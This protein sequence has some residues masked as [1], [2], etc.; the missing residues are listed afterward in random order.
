MP[1]A[2]L[3]SRI[4]KCGTQLFTC[5]QNRK[6]SLFNKAQWMGRL[7]DWS[8]RNDLFKAA[9]FRF[10]DVFPVLRSRESLM[11]HVREYF[12][13]GEAEAPSFMKWGIRMASYGGFVGDEILNGIIHLSVRN[14]AKQFII[15]ENVIQAMKAIEGLRKRGF[16]FTLDILGEATIT[17]EEA[18]Q[19]ELVYFELL[20]NLEKAQRYWT[21]IPAHGMNF[22][23]NKDWGYSPF[24]QISV[25]IS[26]L[27][28]QIRPVD[29]ENSVQ[30]ILGPLKKIY[31]KVIEIGGA[32][33][34][35][36]ESS[37]YKAMTLE[38]FKRLRA[39][40]E[41]RHYVHLGIAIQAY[42]RDTPKDL[43]DLIDWAKCNALPIE[44][45]LVK[46]A[47]WDYEVAIA[48][49]NNWT[50]AVLTEKKETD[51]AFEALARMILENYEV[52]Y[53]ACGSH[54][55]RSI[56]AVIEIAKELKVP[57][58]AYEFQVLYGMAEPI[59]NALRDFVG[60]VRLYCPYGEMISGMAY[61][62]RRLLENT[63]NESFLRQS[64]V[65]GVDIK[66]LLM[67]PKN[68]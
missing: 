15:G 62:V 10:V 68:N 25:K 27:Y 49:Q 67:N 12:I 4:V 26:G 51:A 53:L 18:K 43:E 52:C 22:D 36:M 14:M 20:E 37:Q 5:I 63:S 59:R 30:S 40:P 29:F 8:M 33:C 34:I 56:S 57:E 31:R 39:D 50:P 60:R 23:F 21:A 17:E 35:D 13:E 3:D 64:F 66:T 42:L 54:N 65:E 58:M 24:S 38:I 41:F 7:M 9:L 32:L 6:P 44:I 28:S 48:R 11:R 1:L 16:A 61:L 2:D 55:V 45:R 47:Y 46:G 19:Y